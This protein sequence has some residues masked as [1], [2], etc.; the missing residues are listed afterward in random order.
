[1]AALEAS[2]K[3]AKD[4]RGRHPAAVKP[5]S[6]KPVKAAGSGRR[7]AAA[8]ADGDEEAEEERPAPKKAARTRARKSA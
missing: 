1:M 6:V 8:A 5:S 2:V 4:A 7:G 3:A